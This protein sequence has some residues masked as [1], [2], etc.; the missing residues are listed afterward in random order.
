MGSHTAML[1]FAACIELHAYRCTMLSQ[2][3]GGGGPVSSYGR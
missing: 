2:T 3:G 1:D